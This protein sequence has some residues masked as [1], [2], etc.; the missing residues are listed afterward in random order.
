MWPRTPA[1]RS[2]NSNTGKYINQHAAGQ[3][4]LTVP[5]RNGMS[6]FV[7][8]MNRED[9]E[10]AME[11]CSESDPFNVGRPLMMRWGKNVKKLVKRG[12]GGGIAIAPIRRNQ[13]V[14]SSNSADLQPEYPSGYPDESPR[15]GSRLPLFIE[16]RPDRTNVGRAAV[17]QREIHGEDA[18]LVEIPP[19]RIRYHFISI[20]ASFVA[21]DGSNLERRVIEAESGNQQFNFLTLENASEKQR[22]ENIFYRW[23]VYAFCQGDGFAAWRTDPFVM[24]HPNGRYWIPPVLNAEAARLEVQDELEREDTIKQQKQERRRFTEKREFLTGRQMERARTERRKGSRRG[25]TVEGGAKLT[26]EELKQFDLLVKKELSVSRETICSAMAFC[27]EKSGA[28]KEIAVLLKLALIDENPA[29]TVE[30]RIARLYLLSD[31][32]FNSQQPGVRNAFLYRDAVEK[33]APGIFAR[34]GKHGGGNVGRM[35]MN[36]LRTAISSVLGAWTEWSVYNPTFLDELEARFEGREIEQIPK[37]QKEIEQIPKEQ[38][39]EIE[40]VEEV[41]QEAEISSGNAEVIVDRPRG[42]W[43]EVSEDADENYEQDASDGEPLGSDEVEIEGDDDESSAREDRTQNGDWHVKHDDVDGYDFDDADGED[44]DGAAVDVTE[45]DGASVDGEDIDG[46]PV[47]SNTIHNE[48]IDGSEGDGQPINGTAVGSMAIV[49]GDH[50]GKISSVKDPSPEYIGGED[51]NENDADAE[52]IDGEAVDGIELDGEAIDGADLDS[53]V[54]GS[55]DLDGKSVEGQYLDGEDV[56][57]E[58]LDGEEIDGEELDGEAIDG[59]ELDGEDLDGAVIGGHNIDG[60][61]L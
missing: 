51:L 31:V 42:D 50:D 13:S 38:N 12:T 7:C 48:G 28:A 23:R 29:V 34:L 43:K 20:V 4:S 5:H 54:M 60:T 55:E 2:R 32:L 3:P 33:M 52:D 44:I 53:E 8:F 25:P 49:Y 17:Y 56:D 6:G 10:E 18:I 47:E 26:E 14:A 59:D 1:E 41:K 9:A 45:V 35:T 39:E 24:F 16:T 27:F 37:E 57:E 21:R 19:D 36:K 30:M 11:A 15:R 58:D 22:Q 40:Q 61:P 46:I